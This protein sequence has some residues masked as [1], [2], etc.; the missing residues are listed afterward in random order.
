M[1]GC[2]M[3]AATLLFLPPDAERPWRWW[4]V[5]R[6]TVVAEGEGLPVPDAE[7]P[8]IAIA[9]ADAV[10]LHWAELPARSPA[11]AMAAAQIV[12]SDAVATPAGELHVAVGADR[13]GE[14]AIAVV[15]PD[16]MA[17]WLAQLASDGIDPAAIVPAPLLLPEPEEGYVRGDVARQGIVHGA[18]QRLGG[19]SAADRP[20]HRG[21]RRRRSRAMPSATRR[22][23]CL[24]RSRS[25]CVRGCSP[26]GGGV[27][28]TGRWCGGWGC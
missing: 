26:G 22:R 15:A 17:G 4:R 25:I 5:D 11:Q 12:V 3:T 27:R 19:R 21:A 20:R 13:A 9:P 1:G 23:R 28:S 18:R 7:T 24:R 14:R 16:R 2:T 8:V 6:D 10:T